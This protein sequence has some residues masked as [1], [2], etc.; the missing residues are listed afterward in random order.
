MEAS[1]VAQMVE[2]LVERRVSVLMDVSWVAPRDESM[3]EYSAHCSAA[4]LVASKAAMWV[5]RMD[6]RSVGKR[7]ASMAMTLADGRVFV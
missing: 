2:R 4:C 6:V 5:V 7:A 1:W 3:A